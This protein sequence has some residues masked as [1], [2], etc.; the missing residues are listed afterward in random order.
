M[1]RRSKMKAVLAVLIVLCGTP[2]S[3]GAP[4]G[5]I[6]SLDHETK[7]FLVRALI[8]EHLLP[9]QTSE[10]E[11]ERIERAVREYY[12]DHK[13]EFLLNFDDSRTVD[14]VLCSLGERGYAVGMLMKGSAA[15]FCRSNLR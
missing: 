9:Q 11:N 15:D 2:V 7:K 5:S 12:F 14:M 4:V 1:Q 8:N 10:H 3:A 6:A 13:D